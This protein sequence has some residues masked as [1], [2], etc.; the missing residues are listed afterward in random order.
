MWHCDEHL[1]GNASNAILHEEYITPVMW[2]AGAQDVMQHGYGGIC[3]RV[4]CIG[5]SFLQARRRMQG[6]VCMSAQQMA[7]TCEA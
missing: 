2:H 6:M 4:A 1:H 3:L 5:V 7:Y